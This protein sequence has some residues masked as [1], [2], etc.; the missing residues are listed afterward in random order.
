MSHPAMPVAAAQP[1]SSYRDYHAIFVGCWVGHLLDRQ[2]L[3]EGLEYC[4][5]HFLSPF[6]KISKGIAWVI[7]AILFRFAYHAYANPFIIKEEPAKP[8][9]NHAE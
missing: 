8:E 4:C 1:G 7:I 3:P 9:K 2:R 5:S 6:F